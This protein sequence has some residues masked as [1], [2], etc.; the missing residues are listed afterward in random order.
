MS[1]LSEYRIGNIVKINDPKL[2]VNKMVGRI[3]EVHQY[4]VS[5]NLIKCNVTSA[6]GYSSIAPVKLTAGW[7]KAMGFEKWN[8]SECSGWEHED[9]D[10]PLIGSDLL[11]DGSSHKPFEFVHEIQ[12]AVRA[13]SGVELA[14]DATKEEVKG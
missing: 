11:I 12:N 7:L 8:N 5:I 3:T 13:I 1:I 4:G 14:I 2:P 6:Y 9:I 10:F